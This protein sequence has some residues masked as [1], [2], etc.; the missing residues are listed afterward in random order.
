[1]VASVTTVMRLAYLAPNLAARLL[2]SA[3]ATN[4]MRASPA[5]AKSDGNLHTPRQ[6]LLIEKGVRSRHQASVPFVLGLAAVFAIA[7]AAK[8]RSL[9][10]RGPEGADQT[11][12]FD[13][14]VGWTSVVAHSLSRCTSCAL[15]ERSPRAFLREPPVES[16]VPELHL[17]RKSAVLEKR[18]FH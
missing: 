9:P 1:M 7:L 11:P 17:A 14:I 6:M 15:L 4:L 12:A 16:A 10:R 13:I 3:M 18:A 5:K 8:A 2:K